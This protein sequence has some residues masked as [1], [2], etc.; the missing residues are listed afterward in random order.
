[1][2]RTSDRARLV[3]GMKAVL[4]QPNEEDNRRHDSLLAQVERAERVA[5]RAM[6]LIT[7]GITGWSTRFDHQ[8]GKHVVNY[9]DGRL[10]V[11]Q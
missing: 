5:H 10:E 3:A 8:I 2:K 11:I 7:A 4:G 6:E 9:R 1:M